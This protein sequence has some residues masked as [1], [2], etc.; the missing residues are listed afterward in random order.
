MR[1]LND[2]PVHHAKP[3]CEI[4]YDYADM[5]V[6][7]RLLGPGLATPQVLRDLCDE[8]GKRIDLTPEMESQRAVPLA[9]VHLKFEK[10]A[11]NFQRFFS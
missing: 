7:V 11:I 6:G 8:H 4:S 9:H 1:E 10:V 3:R 5:R 2:P